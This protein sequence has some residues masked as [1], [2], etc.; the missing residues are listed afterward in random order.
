M[1]LRTFRPL[2]LLAFAARL[3]H[4]APAGAGPLR[5]VATVPDLGSLAASVGGEDVEVTSLV[6]GPQDAHFLE[7]RP[8][9]IQALHN[10]DLFVMIG[11]E[12]EVGWV[13]PLLTSARNPAILPGNAGHLDAS[14]AVVPLE[15]PQ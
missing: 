6:K 12:L 1:T 10:A 13:P 9:F 5:V 2:L 4:P 7:P 11:M 14:R 15:V 8:S 3:A